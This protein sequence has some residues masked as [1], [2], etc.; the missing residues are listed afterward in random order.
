MNHS[1][2]EK[3]PLLPWKLVAGDEIK[4][5]LAHAGQVGRFLG[6]NGS[7]RI[8]SFLKQH[9]DSPNRFIRSSSGKEALVLHTFSRGSDGFLE[10]HKS[11]IIKLIRE[12][13][14]IFKK[15]KKKKMLPLES[16]IC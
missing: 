5:A 6:R 14:Q 11:C 16:T 2:P 3:I 13:C 1:I 15:K 10:N 7:L 12:T 8:A 9:I 4:V